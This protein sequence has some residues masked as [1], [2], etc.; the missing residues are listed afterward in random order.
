MNRILCHLVDG[1][2]LTTES[3]QALLAEYIPAPDCYAVLR[4]VLLSNV[5]GKTHFLHFANGYCIP[6]RPVVVTYKSFIVT[7]YA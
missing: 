1:K 7:P 3:L 2:L 5:Y 4:A 6:I